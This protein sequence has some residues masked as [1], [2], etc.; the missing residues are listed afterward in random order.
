[1]VFMTGA[2]FPGEALSFF[3]A[4]KQPKIDKPFLADELVAKLCEALRDRVS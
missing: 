3:R 2:M 1:M 4:T